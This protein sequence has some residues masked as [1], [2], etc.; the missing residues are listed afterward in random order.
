MS[1][2]LNPSALDNR[3]ILQEPTAGLCGGYYDWLCKCPCKALGS[4]LVLVTLASVQ[5]G[6]RCSIT[7]T[8]RQSVD[9]VSSLPVFPDPQILIARICRTKLV[10]SRLLA[11]W[12][13][14][15]RHTTM[16]YGLARSHTPKLRYRNPNPST[17]EFNGIWRWG[18]K[19]AIK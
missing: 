14:I 5:G 4:A 6:L 2:C 19:W 7:H 1:L 3:D 13:R 16:L 11:S 18:F 9:T 17:S 15:S 12:S 8:Q 10:P